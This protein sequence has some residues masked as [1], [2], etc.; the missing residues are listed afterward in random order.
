[1]KAIILTILAVTVLSLA[2]HGRASAITYGRLDGN[3]HP[4]VGALIAEFREP[5]QKDILCS[6]TL[7]SPTVYLTASH[8]TI[9]LESLEI[10]DVWVTFDP[11]FDNSS[12]LLH[13]TYHTNPAYGHDLA[14]LND[15]A[16]VVLDAPVAGVTP[17]QL[18]T[19]GLLDELN[20]GKGLRGQKFTA[21]G[22]GDQ[23]R[24]NGG[25][26]PVFP[27]DGAR[28]VGESEFRTISGNWLRLS[29]NPSLGN[30]GTCFGDS[31]GPNFLGSSNIVVAVTVTGDTACRSTNVDFRLDVPGA[32][33]FLDDY[34]TLP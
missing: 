28:H 27:F 4:N 20:E 18:P 25:G 16:V 30:G 31:G 5:G 11:Q 3:G 10:T 1:M 26:P 13:G 24:Q 21:V 19:E 34:V 15:V 14:R 9:Y 23:E 12:T 32:R 7:I 2:V 8:C 29:Q 22:Y 6:G 33:D 17:A